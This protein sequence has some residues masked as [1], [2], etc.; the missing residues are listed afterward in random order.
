MAF[1]TPCASVVWN[2]VR[3]LRT[4]VSLASSNLNINTLCHRDQG[5][6]SED[7]A[8]SQANI[9][10]HMRRGQKPQDPQDVL[11]KYQ[12]KKFPLAEKR[13]CPLT[14]KT[15]DPGGVSA[16]LDAYQCRRR[17]CPHQDRTLE[18]T[19]GSKSS[20][21]LSLKGPSPL[22]NRFKTKMKHFFQWLC[23]TMKHRAQESSK[24]KT[25]ALS[26]C[27]QSRGRGRAGFMGNTKD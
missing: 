17:S 25:S 24:G 20:P 14:L 11:S 10:T 12:D 19:H 4:D 18:K 13:M 22:E 1:M 2:Q 5:A 26:S 21:T 23:P 7:V 8:A 6:S 15:G 27:V 9:K 16:G 3:G